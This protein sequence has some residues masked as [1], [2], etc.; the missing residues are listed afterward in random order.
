MD[1]YPDLSSHQPVLYKSILDSLNPTSPGEYID[2][3]VGAGGHAWGILQASSP[4]GRLLGLD[5]DPQALEIA[6]K[7]LSLFSERAVL[8]RASYTTLVEQISNLGW[9]NILGIVLDLGVSSLQLDTA[10][11]GFSFLKDGNLDMRFNPGN[12][13]TAAD[14]VNN[15]SEQNLSNILWSFGEERYSRKIAKAIVS[16][17]PIKT[18]LELAHL[19][20]QVY[21]STSERIHPATRTFQALRIAVNQE[22]EAVNS[23]LPQILQVLAPGGR[24]AILSFHS[25]EDRLVKHF[26]KKESVDCICPP[27]QPVCSCNHQAA[28]K[29]IT[30]KPITAQAEE[31][32]LNLRARSAKL[33][34]AQK[35]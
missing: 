12:E 9:K 19:I 16:Q 23:V 4:D 32:K 7:R 31:L 3:T 2:A 27:D 21:G 24:V 1:T 28:I 18:T 14:I 22:L 34:V 35:L 20:K 25:L 10:E 8:I 6:Q 11:R 29:I 26:F 13:L 17:R 30:R 33:R 5:T 15:S